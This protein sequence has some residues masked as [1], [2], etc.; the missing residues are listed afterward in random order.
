MLLL[1]R[2]LNCKKI[3]TN[4]FAF[5][6]CFCLSVKQTALQTE[7]LQQQL[8]PFVPR[9]PKKSVK[10]VVKQKLS[11]DPKALI[12]N[13]KRVVL[14]KGYNGGPAVTNA[15][16][17]VRRDDILLFEQH[18]SIEVA[19]NTIIRYSLNDDIYIQLLRNNFKMMSIMDKS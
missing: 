13:S 19:P 1:V 6:L 14:G 8:Q 2:L 3:F 5:S 10:Q 18:Q 7:Y 4:I 17:V 11:K 12:P 15:V 16:V 9:V